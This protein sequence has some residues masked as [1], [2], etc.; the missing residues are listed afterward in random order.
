MRKEIWPV[1]MEAI[2]NENEESFV[3]M[4]IGAALVG[5]LDA[6]RHVIFILLM[7]NFIFNIFNLHL[8][9]YSFLSCYQI[10]ANRKTYKRHRMQG[11][12]PVYTTNRYSNCNHLWHSLP[13]AHDLC[14]IC[15][16]W[17]L[18]S[19]PRFRRLKEQG[20]LNSWLDPQVGL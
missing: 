4:D 16:P 11:G 20:K 8:Y 7:N 5:T 15:L 17:P 19:R 3:N 12:L 2:F 14:P 13:T 1:C 6:Y 10:E 9:E 18:L